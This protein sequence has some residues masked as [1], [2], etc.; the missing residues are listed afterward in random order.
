MADKTVSVAFRALTDEFEKKVGKAGNKLQEFGKTA[1]V[2]VGG[3]LAA[4]ASIDKFK[5][6]MDSLDKLGKL[7][8]KL[9]IDPNSLRGLQLGAELSGV[10]METLEGGIQKMLITMGKAIDGSKEAQEAFSNLGFSLEDM[11]KLSTEESFLKIAE[12]ISKIEDPAKRADALVRIFGKSGVELTNVLMGGSEAIKGFIAEAEKMNGGIITRDD[13]KSIEEANDALTRLN[14]SFNGL[15]DV[16]VIRFAPTLNKMAVAFQG[17]VE[18]MI[19]GFDELFDRVKFENDVK[20]WKPKIESFLKNTGLT[21]EVEIKP[22]IDVID[23]KKELQDMFS[24]FSWKEEKDIE[25]TD[26]STLD[27]W[28]KM[29]DKNGK[30]IGRRTIENVSTSGFSNAMQFGSREAFSALNPDIKTVQEK[31]AENTKATAEAVK[32]LA[33]KAAIAVVEEI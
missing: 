15:V 25:T 23:Y 7:S 30:F 14:A 33:N 6:R 13:I 8:D 1:L 28:F 27:E 26:K 24:Q 32:D 29:F 4:K 21:T 5:E 12:A 9:N 11:G 31:I 2:A 17:F 10:S 20:D 16:F 3:F 22:S 19:A 18:T